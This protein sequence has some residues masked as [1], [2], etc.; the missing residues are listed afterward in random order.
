MARLVV[1]EYLSLDGVVQAPGHAGEDTDGGFA[2][3]GWTSGY[4]RDHMR[5]NS[6]S[7]PSAGAFLFGRRTYEIFERYWPAV[8]DEGNQIARALN[9]KPKFVASR[10]LE[11]PHWAGTTVIRDVEPE[12]TKLKE[13]P[14]PPIFVIGS[15]GLAQAL[16]Q[17]D[18][19]D[20]YELWLHPVVL[21]GGK[22]LFR[23][24]APRSS[25]RLADSRTTGG[26]LVILTYERAD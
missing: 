15:S 5:L 7:A 13:K 14:G 25:M 21:G 6:L 19:V 20:A 16:I 4:M 11:N 26:G 23:D 9:T 2:H 22:K 24:G 12:V 18:L 3:G 10:T 8:T 1:S 17:A